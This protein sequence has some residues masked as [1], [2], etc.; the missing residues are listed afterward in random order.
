M[1]LVAAATPAV[2]L[3]FF[4]KFTHHLVPDMQL[5]IWQILFSFIPINKNHQKQFAFRWKSRTF[6]V[7]PGGYIKSPALCYGLVQKDLDYLA[8]PQ[9]ITL[10][11][12]IDIVLLI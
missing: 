3:F 11:Q 2:V 7:L 6:T 4:N 8:L 5:M 12:R 10:A 1:T 9:D